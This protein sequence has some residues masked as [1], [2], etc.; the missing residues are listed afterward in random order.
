MA[1]LTIVTRRVMNSPV[2]D[3]N[4]EVDSYNAPKLR[5]KMVALID[6]GNSDVILNLTDVDYID[7]TGLGALVAGL[8]R[9]T[10]R[11]GSVRII[12]PNP[13]ILKVFQ[14]T[15]LVK[16]FTIYDNEESAFA[17]KS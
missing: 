13:A 6:E 17:A 10:E 4:G 5:E 1:D 12:C 11:G 3:L 2:L 14:I 9:A 15:S 7:S 16:V 8:K